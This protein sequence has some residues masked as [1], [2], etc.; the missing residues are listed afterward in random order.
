MKNRRRRSPCA[1]ESF[2]DIGVNFCHGHC[3]IFYPGAALSPLLAGGTAVGLHVWKGNDLLS[4]FGATV[5]Y[6]VL[7]QVVFV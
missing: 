1:P 5:F 4:I 3:H 2:G 7:V 6:M